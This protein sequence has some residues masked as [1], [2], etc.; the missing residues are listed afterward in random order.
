MP[1]RPLFI[2][3][4]VNSENTLNCQ[5][6]GKCGGCSWW[7]LSSQ[8]QLHLKAQRA[9]D[10][11]WQTFQE[12]LE[13]QTHQAFSTQ[14]RDRIDL[15]Y[16]NDAWGMF[17][18]Q[19]KTLIPLS[20]CVL[21]VP[22]LQ[23]AHQE[24]I[25]IPL[26]PQITKASC[27]LRVSPIGD[28]GV[29]LDMANLDIK[30]LLEEAK[31]LKSLKEKNF[32]LEIGQKRKRLQL[33]TN[34]WKLK[35]PEAHPWTFTYSNGRALPLSGSIGSFT[36]SGPTAVLCISEI[37]EDFLKDTDPSMVRKKNC[38]E[39]GAGLG[40]LTAMALPYF[41]SIDIYEWDLQSIH[42]LQTNLKNWSHSCK[43][44]FFHGDFR[45]QSLE[46]KNYDT[47]LLNPARSG[48]GNFLKD[49]PVQKSKQ[50][51]YMSCFFDSFVED[52]KVLR[53]QGYELKKA[54]LVDQFP[55]S[56]HFEFLSNWKLS[57]EA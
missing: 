1:K 55:F 51:I 49:T 39:F 57:S 14:G 33:E 3:N 13:L 18:L 5:F 34:T 35:D 48:M 17:S 23:K 40:T 32:L 38:A 22:A 9:Q 44:E 52:A 30:F 50:I 28:K 12:E 54:H 7:N 2:G 25:D 26:P 6:Q 16:M 19:E 15:T 20:S 46:K 42:F 29:W 8:D 4:Y 36:Q 10:L 11:W 56:S 21:T 37:I 47:L 43:V 27:R 31:Y 53:Q 45:H 41:E 24:F